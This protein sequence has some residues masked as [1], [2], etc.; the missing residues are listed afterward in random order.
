MS[1]SGDDYDMFKG[2]DLGRRK[3]LIHEH[4]DD[5]DDDPTH[6]EETCI[7]KAVEHLH[8]DKDEMEEPVVGTPVGPAPQPAEVVRSTQ[9]LDTYPIGEHGFIKARAMNNMVANVRQAQQQQRGSPNHGSFC[10]T[11]AVFQGTCVNCK[12]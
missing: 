6:T 1:D 8:P 12:S 3:L 11:H 9:S 4:S 5:S 10:C 7:K 2:M